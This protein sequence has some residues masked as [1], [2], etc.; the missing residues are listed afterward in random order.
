MDQLK[1]RLREAAQ[2]HRPDR[3]RILAR[4]ERGMAAP[5]A[6]ARPYRPATRTSWA[7][8]AGAG[9]AVA[10]VLAAGG[11]TATAVLGPD[12]PDHGVAVPSR[13]P[14]SAGGAVDPHSNRFWAQSNITLTTPRP[15]TALT[16]DLRIAQTG[17]VASTG[18]WRTMP[19]EDFTVSVR[20]DGDGALH[21]TWTL[22]PGR[23]APAGR[24][25]F[26]GQYNHAEG[27][28]SARADHYTVTATEDGGERT[29][30]RGGF[31]P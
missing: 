26:A 12:R 5:A 13:V 21:Y 28:R 10:A 25:V 24:H 1:Q 31:A 30:V 7:R 27:A 4:V 19:A 29:S 22:R 17:G 8:V 20:E 15:L 2:A 9:A 23:T 11:Y 16:V 18:H 6:D 3:A 14:L